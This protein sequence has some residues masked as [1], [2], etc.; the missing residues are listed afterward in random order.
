MP[1][2]IARSPAKNRAFNRSGP[3]WILDDPIRNT[4]LFVCI[5]HVHHL[6]VYGIEVYLR[7]IDIPIASN[8]DKGSIV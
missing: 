7:R 2:Q 8:P 6:H 1:N 4:L 5:L 3:P